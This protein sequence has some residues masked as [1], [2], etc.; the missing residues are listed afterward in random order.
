MIEIN[1]DSIRPPSEGNF[2]GER[3]ESGEIVIS[4]TS[5]RRYM[6]LQVKRMG[7]CHKVKCGFQICISS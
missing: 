1:N 7:N 5:L 3:S 6:S 2:S 4:D